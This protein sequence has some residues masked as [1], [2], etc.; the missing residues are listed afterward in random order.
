MFI[1]TGL[2][3]GRAGCRADERNRRA[4]E[5]QAQKRGA[6]GDDLDHVGV[7][8]VFWRA[9]ALAQQCGLQRGVVAERY[10]GLINRRRLNQ[11]LV[12]LKVHK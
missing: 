11:W 1:G 6:I 8:R 5:V 10:D 3:W 9:E 4:R 12:A 2:L 7:G